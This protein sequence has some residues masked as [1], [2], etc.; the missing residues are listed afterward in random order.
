MFSWVSRDLPT[1]WRPESNEAQHSRHHV[2][3]DYLIGARTNARIFEEAP[4]T[5]A[6]FINA[7]SPDE[8]V[9]MPSTTT[10][11]DNLARAIDPSCVD[12]DE[13]IVTGGYPL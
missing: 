10:A 5:T 9:F 11:F 8:I 1:L 13:I 12:T 7:S 3:A 4:A 2:G 6:T